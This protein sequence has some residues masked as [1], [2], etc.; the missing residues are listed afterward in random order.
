M[1]KYLFSSVLE[2]PKLCLTV[3]AKVITLSAMVVNL[4]KGN[5]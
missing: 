4:Y 1:A 5:I 3:E 2:F